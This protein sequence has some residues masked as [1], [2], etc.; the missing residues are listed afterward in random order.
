MNTSTRQAATAAGLGG[1]RRRLF[2]LRP[3][4]A[5]CAVVALASAVEGRAGAVVTTISPSSLGVLRTYFLPDPPIRDLDLNPYS[6]VTGYEPRGAIEVSSAVKFALPPDAGP[7]SPIASAVFYL[8][9]ES[10]F[11]SFG[12][13]PRFSVG[14]SRSDDG[15]VSLDDSYGQFLGDSGRVEL[16]SGTNQ[17]FAFDATD[18]VQSAVVAGTPF[19]RLSIQRSGFGGGINL[20]SQGDMAPRLVIKTIPEPSS[21]VLAGIGLAGLLAARLAARRPS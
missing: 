17:V 9:L 8:T 11:P 5:A 6:L 14:V 19:V 10:A 21:A 12:D 7:H 20:W 2:S 4:A 16:G 15:V 18:F 3:L 13:D 1:G